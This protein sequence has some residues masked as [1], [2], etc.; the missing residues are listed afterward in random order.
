MS[1]GNHYTTPVVSAADV[2]LDHVHALKS[3][4]RDT[5]RQANTETDADAKAAIRDECRE[6]ERKINK[7][8]NDL[9][10]LRRFQSSHHFKSK[11]QAIAA[12]NRYAMQHGML[13]FNQTDQLPVL[14]TQTPDATAPDDEVSRALKE[15]TDHKDNKP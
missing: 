8:T 15:F 5:T 6:L 7:A 3:E 14:Q 1:A 4:L 9:V 10:T 13:T 11:L 2:L 12:F